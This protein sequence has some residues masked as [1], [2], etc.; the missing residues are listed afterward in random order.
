MCYLL[1]F[2]YASYTSRVHVREGTPRWIPQHPSL[3]A[4]AAAR[5]QA[6]RFHRHKDGAITPTIRHPKAP[7]SARLLASP[8]AR[9]FGCLHTETLL[10]QRG[11]QKWGKQHLLI[12]DEPSRLQNVSH[13]IRAITKRRSPAFDR[14]ET[15][16]VSSWGAAKFHV[17][18]SVI[19]ARSLVAIGRRQYQ[20]SLRCRLLGRYRALRRAFC[21]RRLGRCN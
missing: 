17:V 1:A 11:F 20:H 4:G 2:L 3:H 9:I 15:F 5:G 13:P 7:L 16:P 21:L 12:S 10:Y 6:N 8:V 18:V 19:Y 14:R